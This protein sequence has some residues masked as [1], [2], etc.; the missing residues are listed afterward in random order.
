MER[1]PD[2]IARRAEIEQQIKE[3][4]HAAAA[5][6]ISVRLMM[7]DRDFRRFVYG[8]LDT[9]GLNA[10]AFDKDPLTTAYLAGRRSVAVALATE[11]S[12]IDPDTYLKMLREAMEDR[13]PPVEIPKAPP[14]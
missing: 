14:K 12:S 4:K 11:L 6:A 5:R 1:P 9:C 13:A 3:A 7:G 8:L 2:P 10:G